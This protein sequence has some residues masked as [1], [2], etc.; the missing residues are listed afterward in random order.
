MIDDDSS[1]KPGLSDRKA[2]DRR[3]EDDKR[4]R[5]AAALR[6]NLK[7]RKAQAR[8]RRAGPDASEDSGSGG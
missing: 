6:E 3:P 4:A 8:G 1:G 7:K 5:L 2:G